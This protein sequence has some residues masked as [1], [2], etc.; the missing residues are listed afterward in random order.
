[1]NSIIKAMIYEE[2]QS[3]VHKAVEIEMTELKNGKVKTYSF[4][5]IKKSVSSR[6]EP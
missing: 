5:E 4:Q 6:N 1:M 2:E 3:L